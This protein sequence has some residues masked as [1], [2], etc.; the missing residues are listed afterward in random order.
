LASIRNSRTPKRDRR[1]QTSFKVGGRTDYRVFKFSATVSPKEVEARRERLKEIYSVCGG[2]NTLSESIAEHVRKGVVPVPLP[3]KELAIFLGAKFDGWPH[4]RTVLVSQLPSIPWATLGESSVHPAVL[5]AIRHIKTKELNEAAAVIADIDGRKIGKTAKPIPGTLH[6]ALKAYQSYVLS[7][8]PD[9]FD[10][11]GKIRQLLERHPDQPLATLGL[12]A[13]RDMYDYWRQRPPRHDGNGQYSE[14]RSREQLAEL[15]HFFEWLHLSEQF[16]WREP[17]DYQRLDR[18]IFKD[19]A[20]RKSILESKMPVFSLSDLATLVRNAEMP[21]RLWIVWCLNNSHGAAEVGRV[22]WEDIYLNQDHPWRAEGLNIGAGG[23]WIGFLRPKTDVLGWWMLW[24]ETVTLLSQWK[25]Q[26]RALLGRDVQPKDPIILRETGKPLYNEKSKNGQTGFYN[27]FERLKK[28]CERMGTPVADLPPGTLRNQFAD[29]CGGDEANATVASVAL[30]H[31]LPHK[32]DK[33]LYKHYA[34]RPW[35][36]LF[37]KQ[38]EFREYCRPVLVV[39]SE[40][41]PLPRKVRELVEMWPTLPGKKL[42]KVKLAAKRLSVS[43]ATVY[44]Y[45]DQIRATPGL[46]DS[47]VGAGVSGSDS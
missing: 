33:L 1:N 39:L 9:N 8:D 35:R 12:D 32:D 16:L 10:R 18:K 37:E 38:Q 45:L 22:Q 19:G 29:W 26:C 47:G 23:D 31:G 20:S 34:N 4:W 27:H 40:P 42:E 41:P 44:R 28:K 46:D 21:E 14:K 2:W 15:I 43:I 25:G 3:N 30:A 24:P 11:Q 5:G 7:S 17:E 36:K 6:E 13:C